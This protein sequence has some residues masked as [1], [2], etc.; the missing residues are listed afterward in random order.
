VVFP[1][2]QVQVGKLHKVSDNPA[3]LIPQSDIVLWTGPVNSTKAIFENIRP[4]LNTQKTVVG[5]IFA[6]GLVHLLAQRTFGHDV[7]FFALRNIPW[8]C[9][10]SIVGEESHIV[11]GKTSIGVM[12]INLDEAFVKKDLEPLFVMQ[13]TGKWE[14]VV[15]LLPDFCPIVFNPANQI[16]HP[17]RYWGLFRHWRGAPLQEWQEPNE[18]LYRGMDEMAGQVLEALDEELQQLKDAYYE[19][20]GA[21]GCKH[22]IPLRDRLLDQYG[23]QI[24]DKS[25]LAKMIG[26]N[27]AYAMAKTPFIRTKLGVMPN[28]THRVVT[29]DIG[30][31]LCTLLSIA[32]RLEVAGIKTPT[33]M[34]RMLIEWHEKMMGKEFLYNGRLRGRDCA[35]LVL[36]RPSDPLEVVAK[37][38]GAPTTQWLSAAEKEAS[39]MRYGNP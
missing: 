8:L 15:D 24:E 19:A 12:T 21:E 9:R 39:E 17:A 30:W 10:T 29:D 20:T 37:A 7:R 25:T 38:Q 31:G 3:D 13:K 14:P 32:E 27:K 16:I 6:Q 22:V 33:N 11:G 26:T 4:Y 23:D 36:M 18:W 28:P 5:T 2:G 1:D 34:M 35:E